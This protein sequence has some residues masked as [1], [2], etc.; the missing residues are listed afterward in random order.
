MKR[1]LATAAAVGLQLRSPPGS[2]EIRMLEPPLL[3]QGSGF[4]VR[5]GED[6]FLQHLNAFLD[7]LEGSGKAQALWDKWLGKD[8]PYK[9]ERKFKFGNK[10]G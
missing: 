4:G 9:L 5:K 7:K 1:V 8:S 6:A 10:M 3:V 2:P